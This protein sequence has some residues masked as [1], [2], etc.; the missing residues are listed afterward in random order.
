M[1]PYDNA[2]P[3]VSPPSGETGSSQA[4][5][6][7][8]RRGSEKRRRNHKT[9]TRWDDAEHAVLLEKSQDA[10]LSPNG[11]IRTLVLGSPGPRAR[12]K[13]HVNAVEL[14]KAVAALNQSG[15]VL[16]QM[17]HSLNAGHAINLGA[18]CFAALAE[19]QAASAAIR[20]I[21]GRK[22]RDDS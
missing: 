2:P 12:R 21:V 5:P 3:P 6:P 17:Q 15:N 4:Q 20:E 14:G 19:N 22:N 16:N 1:T 11:Y 8:K 9:D 18:A 7:K 13:P 10:A